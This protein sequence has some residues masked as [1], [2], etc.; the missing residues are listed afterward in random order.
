MDQNK[1]FKVNTTDP[2]VRKDFLKM[3]LESYEG[4]K[5]SIQIINIGELKQNEDDYSFDVTIL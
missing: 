3:M 2:T 5:P 4:R 1:T